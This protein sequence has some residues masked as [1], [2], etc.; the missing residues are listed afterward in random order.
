MKGQ[1]RKNPELTKD[2][3]ECL[4][5]AYIV[6]SELAGAACKSCGIHRNLNHDERDIVYRRVASLGTELVNRI[7]ARSGEYHEEYR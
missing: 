4:A 6:S 1:P 7:P 2:Q 5:T 3:I